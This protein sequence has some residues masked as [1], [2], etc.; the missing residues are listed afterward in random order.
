M[1]EWWKE[2]FFQVALP[3]ILT[4]VLSNLHLSKRL[5]DIRTDT[6]RR[7]DAIDK[8][9]HDITVLLTDH[10]QRITRLEERT[11]PLSRR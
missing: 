5:D 10:V 11:S 4:F 2:P 1:H 7:L 3:V 6:N 8:S 9:L